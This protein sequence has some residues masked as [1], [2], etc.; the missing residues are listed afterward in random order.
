MKEMRVCIH[1]PPSAGACGQWNLKRCSVSNC[2]RK[3][4]EAFAD[5]DCTQI[6][7]FHLSM[8]GS[9]TGHR[10]IVGWDTTKEE[11]YSIVPFLG[12]RLSHEL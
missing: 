4:I 6:Y 9:K 7:I 11:D 12:T 3:F 2:G 10:V 5:N 1:A 8:T